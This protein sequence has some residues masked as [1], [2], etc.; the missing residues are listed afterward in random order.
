M[1]AEYFKE[2]I[3]D[4]LKG[5]KCYAK[6]AIELRAMAPMWSK[7]LI[8]MS[9]AELEHST[10]LY[11]MFEEYYQKIYESF[12]DNIP[13]YLKDIKEEIDEIYT[14]YGMKVKYLHEMYNTK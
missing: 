6:K 8:E 13:T 9:A 5:A 11:K 7:I 12:K 2:Q 4:E 14:K 3:C 10:N 1:D